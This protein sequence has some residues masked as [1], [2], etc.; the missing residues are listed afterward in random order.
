MIKTPEEYDL[1]KELIEDNKNDSFLTE[2]VV[3]F[4]ETLLWE[5]SEKALNNIA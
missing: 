2:E 4:V 3:R 1:L 5:Y